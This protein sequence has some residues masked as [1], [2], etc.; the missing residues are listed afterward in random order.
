MKSKIDADQS[1]TNNTDFD[2]VLFDNEEDGEYYENE[3]LAVTEGILLCSSC[4]LVII[5]SF[6]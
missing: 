4:F 2:E 1:Q 5:L 6:H 3:N